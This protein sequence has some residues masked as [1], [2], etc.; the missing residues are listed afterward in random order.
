MMKILIKNIF[1]ILFL[2]VTP[3][4]SAILRKTVSAVFII[5]FPSSV[6]K[7]S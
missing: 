5:Q 3:F 4:D 2:K 6:A 7:L 1:L